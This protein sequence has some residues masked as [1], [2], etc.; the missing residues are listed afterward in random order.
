M[1]KKTAKKLKYLEALE[2]ELE[3]S[4]SNQRKIGLSVEREIDKLLNELSAVEDNIGRLESN[5][6]I[7][8]FKKVYPKFKK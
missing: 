6:K 8:N 2:I 4:I 1:N 7:A 3:N 5:G